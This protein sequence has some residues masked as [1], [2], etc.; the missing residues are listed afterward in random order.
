VNHNK[1][2][3]NNLGGISVAHIGSLTSKKALL[4]IGRSNTQKNSLPLESLMEKLV[5]ND[6][7][8]LWPESRKKLISRQLSDKSKNINSCIDK[9]LGSNET[10][11]KK[12]FRKFIKAMILLLH[13]SKWDYLFVRHI[14]EAK[15]D[16]TS[17]YRRAIQVYGKNRALGILSHSAGGVMAANL[18]NESN[19]KCI[20]CFG[21]PFKHPDR[22]NEGYRV[23]N[24]K[25]TQIP[26]LIFQGNKDEYGGAGVEE[27]YELSKSIEINYVEATHEYDNL[28]DHDWRQV[29][30]RIESFLE[31][32]LSSSAVQKASN[33]N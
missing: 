22:E 13:P 3:F 15:V 9:L 28:H 10:I 25:H 1:F 19:L 26:F 8:L 27:R 4:F 6:Y 31:S 29:V 18:Q 24:L 16:Q 12:Y 20:I 2:Q 5:L 21:Y 32:N 7:L 33:A 11:V 30:W 23:E 14:D 17:L